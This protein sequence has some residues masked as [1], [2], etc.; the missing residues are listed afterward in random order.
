MKPAADHIT[1]STPPR[2]RPLSLRYKL[3]RVFFWF[4]GLL[5]LAYCLIILPQAWFYIRKI[6]SIPVDTVTSVTITRIQQVEDT[7]RKESYNLPAAQIS[8]L[9]NLVAAAESYWPN[10]PQTVDKYFVEINTTT[11]PEALGF[12][13]LSTTNNG[14]LIWVYSNGIDMGWNYGTLRN[15]GLKPILD[16][17]PFKK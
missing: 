13:I 5:V 9:I 17:I 11:S 4:V 1:N 8:N 12:F 6:Q 10:H 16:A 15:D 14:T 7:I 2:Q 3:F